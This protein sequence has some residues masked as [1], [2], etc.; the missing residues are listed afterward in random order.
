[1]FTDA[2]LEE[3]AA[4]NPMALDEL[5]RISG[6][7]EKKLE[8][9]GDIFLK[10]IQGF[11]ARNSE[12]FTG[13]TY[14]LTY[15]LFKQGHPI[16][17]I[18]ADRSLTPSTILSHLVQVYEKGEPVDVYQFISEYE[19]NAVQK[20]LKLIEPPVRIR[21]VQYLLREEM[22]PHKIRFALTYL[23]REKGLSF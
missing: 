11:L 13:S 2:A 15:E 14:R 16:E 1:I 6:I 19:I 18:A 7:G 9:Y 17:K 8:Q 3:M 21:D 5:R 23:K 10:E 20:T 22:E 12:Q 4:A